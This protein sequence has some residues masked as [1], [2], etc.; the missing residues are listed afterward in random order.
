MIFCPS[1][2]FSRPRAASGERGGNFI[3]REGPAQPYLHQGLHLM[4][5]DG[6][7]AELHQ[8]LGDAERQGPQAGAIASH[9]DQR[10]HAC[11]RGWGKGVRR[12]AGPGAL[13]PASLSTRLL[14]PLSAQ[15]RRTSCQRDF[16]P[17]ASHRDWA[18]RS[19]LLEFNRILP[20]THSGFSPAARSPAQRLLPPGKERLPPH[21]ISVNPRSD[22]LANQCTWRV[23]ALQGANGH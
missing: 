12:H 18:P 17:W 9:Q 21:N 13:P 16:Q 20:P 6:F 1:Q 2:G 14:S 10:L 5:E 22:K 15:A 23:L 7:V 8:R 3:S 11:L 19:C 4:Q